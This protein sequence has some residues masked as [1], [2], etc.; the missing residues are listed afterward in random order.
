MA[1]INQQRER[2]IVEQGRIQGKSD[3]F[4]KAAVTRFREQA[5]EPTKRKGVGGVGGFALG[6]LKGVGKTLQNIGQATLAAP[7]LI[8]GGK[9]FGERLGEIKET[10][11]VRPK[12]L[13]AKGGAER[14]GFITERIA[15]FIAPSGVVV[16]GTKALGLAGKGI[17][18]LFGRSALEAGVVGGQTLAQKGEIDSDVK[19]AA[20]IG[21]MFPGLGAAI[22][23][24]PSIFGATG[25]KVQTTVIK[26]SQKDL[27]D[28]FKIENVNKY[29]LGGSLT[30]TLEKSNNK[31]NSLSRELTKTIKTTSDKGVTVNLKSILQETQEDLAQRG[32]RNF[33]NI[34]S[35]QNQL[36]SLDGEITEIA[37]KNGI[38][39]FIEA[40]SVKRGAGG[41]GSWVFGSADPDARAVE[42]VYTAFYR[43]LLEN[44]K[45]LG[46]PEMQRLNKQISEIIPI[47]NAVVRRTPIAERNNAI[48]ITDT[49]A[50]FASAFHPAALIVMGA[51]RLQRAGKFGNILVKASDKLGAIT[52]P[53]SAIGQRLFVN[54][55]SQLK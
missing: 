41:K 37:G 26:P 4:I 45:K 5:Q 39:D 24:V 7:A 43:K 53:K 10:T 30:Q 51:T 44:M 25:R 21:A 11:G 12:T 35:I 1:I 54:Q 55:A 23:K 33:G 16:K 42:V 46:S 15:E 32:G 50:I 48:S 2:Q 47:H 31:L 38:V 17:K 19:T 34:K 18:K 22:T 6:A 20:I 27:K 14:A 49:M 40:Q 28:G 9:T 36:K 29:N 3:E 8:P 13:E 52:Q